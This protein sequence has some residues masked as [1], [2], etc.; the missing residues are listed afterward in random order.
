MAKSGGAA[1]ATAAAAAGVAARGSAIRRG[2]QYK[3]LFVD[4]N[5]SGKMSPGA[6]FLSGFRLQ[7]CLTL[8]MVARG[9]V[10][11]VVRESA[12]RRECSP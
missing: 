9:L 1:A 10:H 5:S 8:L 11:A 7:M 2:R 12:T 6:P 3:F 4:G